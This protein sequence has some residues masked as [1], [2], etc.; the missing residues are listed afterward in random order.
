MFWT[1]F[2]ASALAQI[3][4]S[5]SKDNKPYFEET[6]RNLNQINNSIK[7]IASIT[8]DVK[9]MK[10]RMLLNEFSVKC[11]SKPKLSF[12]HYSVEDIMKAAKEGFD[13]LLDCA[14]ADEDNFISARKKFNETYGNKEWILKEYGDYIEKIKSEMDKLNDPVHKKEGEEIKELIKILNA[15]NEKAPFILNFKKRKLWNINR[16]H[17][18]KRLLELNEKYLTKDKK[19]KINIYSL[20]LS[21]FPFENID[22][23][24]VV[25]SFIER[26]KKY[27]EQKDYDDTANYLETYTQN[28]LESIKE[29]KENNDNEDTDVL[30]ISKK[31]LVSKRDYLA[32]RYGDIRWLPLFDFD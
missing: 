5:N 10:A 3:L 21:S 8:D 9:L 7:E 20:I 25:D 4:F 18:K 24:N 19:Y 13:A 26:A 11:I 12:V 30:I 29:I 16:E 28:M 27:L 22:F 23:C 14:L 15:K 31:R 6:N 32:I 1:M 2:G 17:N